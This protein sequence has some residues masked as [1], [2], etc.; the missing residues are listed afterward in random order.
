MVIIHKYD[1]Y[2]KYTLTILNREKN[3]EKSIDNNIDTHHT[4]LYS[5][6]WYTTKHIDTNDITPQI[7]IPS[8]FITHNYNINVYP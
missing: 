2:T 4:Y 8:I 7:I 6:I 5:K 1:K 3:I